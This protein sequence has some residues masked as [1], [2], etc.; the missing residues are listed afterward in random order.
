MRG[1]VRRGPHADAGDDARSH[2]RRHQRAAAVA[3]EGQ[4]Q[5][6][7]REQAKA[8][9]DVDENMEQE[10]GCNSD[11]DQAVHVIRGLHT[12]INA[13]RD[14]SQKKKQHHKA[15]DQPELLTDGAE[16]GVRVPRRKRA[17]VGQVAVEQPLTGQTAVA[18]GLEVL[19]CLPQNALTGRVDG[20]I[21]DGQNAVFLVV[22]QDVR[23]EIGTYRRER[24]RR[25]P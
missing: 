22:S 19:V 8:H 9:A 1:D 23:P 15:S 17:R 12:H 11:A 14:E 7:D 6:D 25:R 5:T 21:D 4:R 13:P 20:G 16:N 24:R 3:E 2:E 18:Q 10:H